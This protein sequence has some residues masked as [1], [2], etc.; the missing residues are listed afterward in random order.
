PQVKPPDHQV[1]ATVQGPSSCWST[2][3]SRFSAASSAL[4]PRTTKRSIATPF[5]QYICRR[6]SSYGKVTTE[7]SSE[8]AVINES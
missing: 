5:T 3:R 1:T 2:W 7:T 8:V 4:M 6:S